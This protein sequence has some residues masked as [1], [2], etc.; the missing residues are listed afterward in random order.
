ML[1]TIELNLFLNIFKL[2][3][4]NETSAVKNN[5]LTQV[6]SITGLTSFFFFLLI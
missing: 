4:C 6:N 2:N 3:I 5:A 1:V